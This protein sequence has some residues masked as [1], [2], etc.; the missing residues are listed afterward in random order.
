MTRSLITLGLLCANFRQII[1]VTRSGHD[2]FT[3][4]PLV[5]LTDDQK[6]IAEDEGKKQ[7][8]CCPHLWDSDF[9]CVRCYMRLEGKKQLDQ[10]PYL[11]G[12][13]FCCARCNVRLDWLALKNHIAKR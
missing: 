12:P 3:H 5:L 8:D 9:C 11:W 6:V 13:N 10:Y 1:H 2:G 7:L 4:P